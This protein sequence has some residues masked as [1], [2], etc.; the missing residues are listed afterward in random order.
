MNELKVPF[1]GAFSAPP[2]HTR[3]AL[4]HYATRSLAE[5][6]RKLGRARGSTTQP[7]DRLDP[8]AALK[9]QD[10]RCTETCMAGVELW[11]QC[12]SRLT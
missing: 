12:C 6:R 7:R 10:R 8:E 2:S 11:K 4:H 9:Q 5:Y 3:I 1:E